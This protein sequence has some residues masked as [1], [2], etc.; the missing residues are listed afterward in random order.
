MKEFMMAAFPWLLMGLALAVIAARHG[1]HV[2][3]S[4]EGKR[5]EEN[6][7]RTK[8]NEQI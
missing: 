8:T 2:P 4:G 1:G 7:E 5:N 3:D 6:A